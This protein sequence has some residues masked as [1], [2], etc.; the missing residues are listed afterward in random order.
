MTKEVGPLVSVHD[1]RASSSDPDGFFDSSCI[2]I[3]L[4]TQDLS[5]VPIDNMV[6]LDRMVRNGRLGLLARRLLACL[7]GVVRF[8]LS[9]PVRFF[10]VLI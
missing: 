10:L 6:L 5:V 4:F 1:I 7:A 8:G 3:A 9:H 2:C